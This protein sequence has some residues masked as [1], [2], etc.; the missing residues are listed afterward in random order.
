MA[1]CAAYQISHSHFLGGP[2]E[3]TQLDRDKAIWWLARTA[4]T[5]QGCGTRHE[6]WDPED[7][8]HPDAYIGA[9]THC[10]GCEV[11]ASAQESFDKQ[12]KGTFRRG[13]AITLMRN[14]E[15]PRWPS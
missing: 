14:P 10:R 8:G 11:R 9:L 1:V 13:T 2:P 12:P 4:A 3:W 5:C 15:V 7:G 6:E